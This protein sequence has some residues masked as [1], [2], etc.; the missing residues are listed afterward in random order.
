MP[1]GDRGGRRTDGEKEEDEVWV[2]RCQDDAK[3]AREGLTRSILEPDARLDD[4]GGKRR[5]VQGR[6]ERRA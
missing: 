4:G 6:A 1:G 5:A 2:S 3:E